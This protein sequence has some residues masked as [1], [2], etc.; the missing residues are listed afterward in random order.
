VIHSRRRS[1]S[2][3]FGSRAAPYRA[4]V[5]Y[6]AASPWVTNRV[7]ADPLLGIAPLE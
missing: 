1:C 5:R 3:D 4:S 6:S 7:S 2:W